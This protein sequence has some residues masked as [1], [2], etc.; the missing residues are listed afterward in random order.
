MSGLADCTVEEL[1]SR[2][3]E[4]SATPSEALAS[5][6][7]RVAAVD[8]DINAVLEPTLEQ[9]SAAAEVSDRRWADGTQRRLEGVPFGVKDLIATEGIRTTGGSALF[10]DN[11]PGYDAAVVE[12]LTSAGAVMVAK[13]QTMELACGGA[14]NRTFGTSRNPWNRERTTGGTSSGSGAAV[15]AGELPFAIGTDTGGSIRIPAAYC[16]ATGLKPTYGRVPRHGVMGLSWTLDH[17]GPIT[18]T[19]EDAAHVL[20]A[21]A[22]RDDRDP[23]SSHRAVPDYRPAMGAPVEGLRVGRPRGWFEEIMEPIV[24]DAFDRAV[25]EVAAMGVTVVDVD[26]PDVDIWDVASWTIVYTEALSY[27]Q[28]YMYDVENRDAML[29]GML[30]CSPYV[31]AVDYA[32]ALRYRRVAQGQ[33]ERAME[34]LA[35]LVV[36]GAI[37]TAPP[38]GDVSGTEESALWMLAATRTTL[39]F[40][41]TGS[42]GLCVPAGLA[43]NLPTSLQFVGRP[44]DEATLFTLGS[45]FQRSTRHHLDRPALG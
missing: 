45:A 36:P 22:G 16:G 38:L 31:H 43:G 39:P 1:L 19:V 15:S 6:L 26:L 29:A 33:L 7:E 21:V 25:D 8:D 2:F 37:S 10:R 28:E 13:L 11:V 20:A 32:R 35:A 30:A 9:A 3:A 4:G 12:R 34:G 23:T 18:R 40:N 41:F 17:V 14:E 24:A 42:P 5:C 27:H 44:H